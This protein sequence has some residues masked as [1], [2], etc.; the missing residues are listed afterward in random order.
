[1]QDWWTN[2]DP[3]FKVMMP[4]VA[5]AVIAA[6]VVLSPLSGIIHDRLTSQKNSNGTRSTLYQEAI[7]GVATSPLFGFGSPRASQQTVG[8]NARV[9]TQGQFYLVLF[10]HGI[11]ATLCYL[12]WFLFTALH[13]LRRKRVDVILWN[14][15]ILM[16]FSGS[17][18]SGILTML[19]G[20]I[21]QSHGIPV[22]GR[23]LVHIMQTLGLGVVAALALPFALIALAAIAGNMVQHRLVW[24][25]ESLKP[26]LSKIS[27]GAGFG[28]L[29]SKVALVNFVKGLIKLVLMVLFPAIT[30]WL[31]R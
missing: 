18:S 19:R 23:G 17:M 20:L 21:A 16:S 15:V 6:I 26:K 24:S 10:S 11:P 31:P 8:S 28:R 25:A 9:G 12:G 1:M 29:F 13:A 3:V 2:P 30:L 7:N 27:L 4:F 22:D 14:C 5:I